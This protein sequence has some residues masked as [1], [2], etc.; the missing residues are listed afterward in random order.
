MSRKTGRQFFSNPGPTNIPDSVLRAMDRPAIDFMDPEFMEV[1]RAGGGRAEAGAA[2][3]G[4]DVPVHR[5]RPRR[6]GSHAGEPA[7]AGRHRAR[8]ESGWFSEGWAEMARKF[9]LRPQTVS[10][11]WRRGADPQAVDG[12]ASGRQRHEIK[13]VL[14]VHNETRPA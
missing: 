3:R 14:A 4:R 8:R 13:A 6:L 12:G 10:A 9:G 7:L 11:D 5:L 2:D 1:F